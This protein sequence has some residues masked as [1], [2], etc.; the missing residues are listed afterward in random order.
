VIGLLERGATVCAYDPV[1]VDEARGV[2][3]SICAMLLKQTR[4]CRLRRHKRRVWTVPMRYWFTEWKAFKSPDFGA[5]TQALTRPLI[6]T[7][8]TCMNPRPWGSW[9]SSTTA[10][11]GYMF[12]QSRIQRRRC[13]SHRA[14]RRLSR[15]MQLSLPVR[16]GA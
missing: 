13:M 8:E 5:L 4:A 3:R 10:L 15:W 14:E 16:H 6:L 9:E 2:L 12:R 1:A 11:V 7:A